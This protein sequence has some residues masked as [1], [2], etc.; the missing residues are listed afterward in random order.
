MLGGNGN[1]NITVQ[2]P[3]T[4]AIDGG[5][6]I[7][8]LNFYRPD[9]TAAVTVNIVSDV[10]GS[11]SVFGLPDGTTASNIELLTLQTGSGDDHVT[12]ANL[13]NPGRQSWDGGAG[14]DSATLDF[15]AFSTRL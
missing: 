14:N 15:S 11:T 10:N 5:S 8:W 1:D 12:F 2:G 13:T 7:D 3:G 4:D 9:L 6:G